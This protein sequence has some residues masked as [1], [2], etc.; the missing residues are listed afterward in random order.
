MKKT[1]LVI[2]SIA[3]QK[4]PVL[5]QYA[6][7][8]SEKEI[9]FIVVG[10]TKSPAHFNLTH[11][12]Y[13]GIDRQKQLDFT[14]PSELPYNHYSRKNIGYLVAITKGAEIIIETDDDNIPLENFWDLRKENQSASLFKEAGWLNVYSFFTKIHIWPRGFALN[15]INKTKPNLNPAEII[16]CPIQQGLSDGDSDVDAIYRLTTGKEI[17]FASNES[18]AIGEGTI[19][20]FNSQNTTWFKE[21]FPLLYLPSFCSF[22]MTDIWRSYIAQRIAW[23]CGWSILFHKSSTLQVR[24]EHDLMQDF[25]DEL[26]G[27]QNADYIV[28]MLRNLTLKAGIQ[29]IAE[30]MLICY[31][32]L[33]DANLIGIQ[34][35][36]L[37]KQWLKDLEKI[38]AVN[39][40]SINGD[41]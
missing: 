31:Q 9:S 10:D 7:T 32:S 26:I 30:N 39:L 21:S 14:L 33:V 8:A 34:E 29:F 24:N 6:K 1:F 37:L 12:D 2:T 17:L 25:K 5:N 18:I 19:C 35:I 15:Y 3:S 16:Y 11:C 36:T 13:Y 38:N 4:H 23:T 41:I 20:P 40:N 27:Y 22:R 28:Q